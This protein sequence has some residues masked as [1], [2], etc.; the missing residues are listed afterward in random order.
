MNLQTLESPSHT[1]DKMAKQRKSRPKKQASQ[2]EE[3]ASTADSSTADTSSGTVPQIP[4]EG[5]TPETATHAPEAAPGPGTS[6]IAIGEGVETSE[7][8]ANTEPVIMDVERPGPEGSMTEATNESFVPAPSGET[9][10]DAHP[11]NKGSSFLLVTTPSD[12]AGIPGEAGAN[13]SHPPPA[14]AKDAGQKPNDQARDAGNLFAED[15]KDSVW[16]MARGHNRENG[17]SGSTKT[18]DEIDTKPDEAEDESSNAD[19]QPA[20]SFLSSELQA[21]VLQSRLAEF[22]TKGATR[23]EAQPQHVDSDAETVLG[24]E[25][26]RQARLSHEPDESDKVHAAKEDNGEELG[27]P[28]ELSDRT[29]QHGEETEGDPDM[30]ETLTER[31]KNS[32][33]RI[34]QDESQAHEDPGTESLGQGPPRTNDEVAA[35]SERSPGAAAT[36]VADADKPSFARD[37]FFQ[38]DHLLE[39]DTH[40]YGT[41]ASIVDYIDEVGDMPSIEAIQE[42]NDFR[43]FTAQRV[44]ILEEALEDGGDPLAALRMLDERWRA[45]WDTACG[46]QLAVRLAATRAVVHSR[47][48][49]STDESEFAMIMFQHMFATFEE[50]LGGEI[51]DPVALQAWDILYSDTRK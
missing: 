21:I 15:K 32:D 7:P 35:D 16:D 36:A 14:E 41:I 12:E 40:L 13:P 1:Q 5:E 17:Q 28:V 8:A 20:F 24:V 2:T 42:F 19:I 3:S 43:G 47:D 33:M 27:E 18:S 11:P 49:Q 10:E 9:S 44:K 30:G 50:R 26:G 25:K 6:P 31:P 38:K 39:Q 22:R 23:D 48:P 29:N 34:E 37:L 51:D 4:P 46:V 45:A